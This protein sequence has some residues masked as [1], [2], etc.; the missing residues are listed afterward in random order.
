MVEFMYA[1]TKKKKKMVKP[2]NI[3]FTQNIETIIML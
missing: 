3:F 2:I 1:E